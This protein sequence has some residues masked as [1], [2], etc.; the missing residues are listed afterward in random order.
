MSH[1][2]SMLRFLGSVFFLLALSTLITSCAKDYTK[3]NEAVEAN[4]TRANQALKQLETKPVNLSPLKVDDRPWFGAKAVPISNGDMLPNEL[5]RRD[6]LVLT[7]DR[8][9]TFREVARLIHSVTGI[10]TR[11]G[12]DVETGEDEIL[13]LPARGE[14]ISGGRIIWQ[15][16]LNSLLDEV[17]DTFKSQWSYNGRAIT[18][19]TLVTRTYM[20]HALASDITASGSVSGGTSDTGS[21]PEVSLSDSASLEVW[22]EVEGAINTILGDNGDSSFSPSTGTI[23]VRGAPENV[24]QVEQYLRIQNSMRLRRV[25]VSVKVLAIETSDQYNF[26]LDLQGIIERAVDTALIDADFNSTDGMSIGVL[27]GVDKAGNAVDTDAVTALLEANEQIDRVAIT[28][29]GAIVTLSDQPAP[30]QVGRQVSYLERVSATTDDTGGSTSIEPGTL[31]LGLMMTILPRIIQD[32]RILMRLS[33]AITD[34]SQPFRSF[35]SGDST[36]ELP[37]VETTGFLQNAVLNDGETLVLAGFEKNENS[38]DDSGAPGGFWT[39]GSRSTNRSRELSVLLI[40][41][42]ILPEEPL[43]ILGQ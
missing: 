19:D 36:V 18:F 6:G 17:A 33:V 7:F 11:V 15:G 34:A 27:K 32:D 16:S 10:R 38:Y 8:P 9:L 1:P 26:N 14:Q 37:E 35:T 12:G 2:F 30:L 22:R 31:D 23:T 25:A 39:G 24:D 21:L 28:H 40:S 4:E 29:S 20:L 3:I 43:T 13:F 41:A 42:Q 5:L